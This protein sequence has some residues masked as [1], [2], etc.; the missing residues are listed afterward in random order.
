MNTNQD[1][2]LHFLG[3]IRVYKFLFREQQSAISENKYPCCCYRGYNWLIDHLYKSSEMFVAI[4]TL[5]EI[6]CPNTKGCLSSYVANAHVSPIYDAPDDTGIAVIASACAVI[7]SKSYAQP[8][9]SVLVYFSYASRSD[10]AFDGG[11]KKQAIC[12][13]TPRHQKKE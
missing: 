13:R 11:A 9:S 1:F 6:Q 2:V 8:K 4:Q 12:E 10:F 7:F 3:K 5:N